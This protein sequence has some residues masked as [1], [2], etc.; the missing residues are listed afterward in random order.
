MDATTLGPEYGA[1]GLFASA[2]RAELE[3]RESFYKCT[4]HDQKSHDING[5][6]IPAGRQSVMQPLMSS[7]AATPTYWIP[8]N[9]RRPNNPYRIGR[10]MVSSFTGMLFSHGRWPQMRSDDPETQFWAEALVKASGLQQAMIRARNAGGSCGVVGLSWGWVDGKPRVRVHEGKF[11]DCLQ[12][13]DKDERCPEH[14][15][16]LYKFQKQRPNPK[17]GKPELVDF[18]HRRDWTLVADVVFKDV[19]VTD[20]EPQWDLYIDHEKTYQH[21]HD[22][23]HFEWVAN[24]PDDALE[25]NDGQPDYPEVYEPMNTLDLTNSVVVMGSIRNLDP[26][27]VLRVEPEVLASGVVRKGSDNALAVGTGGDAKYLELTGNTVTAGMALVDKCAQQI[28]ETC[29]CVLV[30]PDKL[31]ASGMSSVALKIIYAPMIA[32]CDIMRP[33]YGGAIERVLEGLTDYARLHLPDPNVP[34]QQVTVPEYDV[35]LDDEGNPLDPEL[36]EDGNVLPPT[37]IEQPVVFTFDLPNRKVEEPIKDA[38][39]NE[40][41]EQQVTEVPLQPG[42]GAIT[43]EWGEYFKP[44]ADDLQKSTTSLGAAV[45]GK[46]IMSQRTAVELTANLFNRDPNQEWI[47]VSKETGDARQHELAA[48]SGMFPGAGAP[49]GPSLPA[50]ENPG[51]QA[52]DALPEG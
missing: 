31:A 16:E 20:D 51:S 46:P 52:P 7:N 50:L 9:A 43:I 29:D 36:D 33:Q 40:T 45:A 28:L 18:W 2:R 41:G 24:M 42:T 15:T 38:E 25:S 19:E 8:M 22:R 10:K 26:T 6:V 27:L 4:S 1:H 12:W 23:I 5:M 35:E 34:G 49:S 37:P 32:K 11:I 14:V 30:D 47:D 48:A 13:S 17:T 39:G 3:F 44:T 21:N